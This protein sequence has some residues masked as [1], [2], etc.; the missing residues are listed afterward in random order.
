MV[1]AFLRKFLPIVNFAIATAA[2]GFQVFVLYPWHHQLEEDFKE[3]QHQQETKLEEYHQLK[4]QTIKNIEDNL[5]KLT[6]NKEEK[7]PSK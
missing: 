1:N 7:P 4:M 3:L 2:L 5:V 6:V